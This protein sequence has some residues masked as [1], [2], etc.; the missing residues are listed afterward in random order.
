MA[1]LKDLHAFSAL[2]WSF[3]VVGNAVRMGNQDSLEN[4][5]A[6]GTHLN[7]SLGRKNL[8]GVKLLMLSIFDKA[9]NSGTIQVDEWSGVEVL[10]KRTSNKDHDCS[11]VY[12]AY[13]ETDLLVVTNTCDASHRDERN[14]DS[15]LLTRDTEAKEGE[16]IS[17][18]AEWTTLPGAIT[19]VQFKTADISGTDH[20]TERQFDGRA[21]PSPVTSGECSVPNFQTYIALDSKKG[22]LFHAHLGTQLDVAQ[23][24][25]AQCASVDMDG[26]CPNSHYTEERCSVLAPDFGI[27]MGFNG[28]KEDNCIARQNK[29]ICCRRCECEDGRRS[30]PC[31][32]VA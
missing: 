18:K 30:W 11:K 2:V 17:M 7:E 25:Y 23:D 28:P 12:T 3:T 16:T 4:V 9:G 14:I 8:C 31:R 20:L 32:A 26:E 15:F 27:Q 19:K 13:C 24:Q 5:V 22:N 29:L 10:R 6:T 21:S 1:V